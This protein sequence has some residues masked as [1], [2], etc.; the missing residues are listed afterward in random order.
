MYMD[1]KKIDENIK[2]LLAWVRIADEPTKKKI[3]IQ[4]NKLYRFEYEILKEGGNV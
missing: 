4:L 2:R 1:L 3:G